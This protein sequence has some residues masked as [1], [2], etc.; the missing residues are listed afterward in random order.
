[1]LIAILILTIFNTGLIVLIGLGSFG[2]LRE[3]IH[4]EHKLTR[5]NTDKDTEIAL[6]AV[7]N[8][9]SLKQKVKMSGKVEI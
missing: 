9:G 7:F 8:M 5:D 2:S 1:M 3:Q 6:E 4:K